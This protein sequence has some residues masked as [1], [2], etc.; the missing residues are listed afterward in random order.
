L[1]R[2]V[3]TD[4]T[5]QVVYDIGAYRG[6]WSKAAAEVLPSA[7]FLLFEANADNEPHL[8]GTGYRYFIGALAGEDATEKS[9][10]LPLDG[11]TTGTSLYIENTTHYANHNLQVRSVPTRRLDAVIAAHRLPQPDLIKIDVQGA[12][13]DVMDGAT[14]ALAGASAMILETSFIS[15]NKGAPL[16]ADVVAAVDRRGM[17]CVDVC[18]LHRSSGGIA[19]QMDLLFVRDHLFER[20]CA[21]ACQ[22]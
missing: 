9:L 20:F 21:K 7:E 5:P 17:K 11:D 16:L 14:N 12:E 3:A 1:S 19:L 13:L 18:E 6:A 15:Y 4:F 10:F 22:L 8:T 2:L